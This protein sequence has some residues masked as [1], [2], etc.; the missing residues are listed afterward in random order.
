MPDA[1]AKPDWDDARIKRW[2]VVVGPSCAEVVGRIF[3]RAKLKEQ[4][5]NPS[6]FVLSLSKKYGRDRLEAACAHALPRLTSPRYR[7][8]K[9]ILDSGLDSGAGAPSPASAEPPSK[10]GGHVRGADYYKN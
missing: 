3:D 5:Y 2:A 1:F 6:L 4:A 8:I 7:H 9:A 10:P